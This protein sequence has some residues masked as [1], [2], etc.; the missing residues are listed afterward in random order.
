MI[1][2]LSRW[3]E[4]HPMTMLQTQY[5]SISHESLLWNDKPL[6]RNSFLVW[7]VENVSVRCFEAIKAL[8]KFT[9]EKLYAISKRPLPSYA[10][11]LFEE[12]GFVLFENY[13]ESADKKIMDLIGVHQGCTHL[14][15]IS[16]DSDFV[17]CVHRFLVH[18]DVHWIMNDAN[19]KG[20]CMRVN[21]S[22][23]RLRL[24]TFVTTPIPKPLPKKHRR[25]SSKKRELM[26]FYEKYAY[27]QDNVLLEGTL[28]NE[29]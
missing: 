18:H 25:H 29:H 5:Q 4:N 3:F 12:Q 14:I 23:A 19:K 1:K 6:L 13:P 9:P 17:P 26:R 28:E 22:H 7:D 11:S 24:S 2:R 27:L 16:S 21:L 10:L 20:I 8:V 15:L